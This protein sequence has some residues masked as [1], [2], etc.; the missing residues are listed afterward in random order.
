MPAG[1]VH[2]RAGDVERHHFLRAALHRVDQ[3]EAIDAVV[4][5]RLRL[6]VHFLEPRH[7]S[8]GCRLQH[9][10]VGWTILERA[11]EVLG[12][13]GVADAIAIGEDDAVGVVAGDGQ[14][15]R[16][17]VRRVGGKRD[18]LAAAE[19]HL[20]GR[21]RP[22]GEDLHPDA[23]AGRRVDVAAVGLGPRREPQAGRIGVVDV[24]PRHARRDRDRN[25][26]GRRGHGA[27]DDAILEGRA[28][29]W[30]GEAERT[31]GIAGHLA[32]APAIAVRDL[33]L[34]DDRRAVA[35]K[36]C[37]DRE[38]RAGLDPRV[39]RRHLEADAIGE[40]GQRRRVDRLT[41]GTARR[42]QDDREDHRGG[43]GAEPGPPQRFAR[44]N[45]LDIDRRRPARGVGDHHLGKR[46]RVGRLGH[47]DGGRQPIAERRRALLDV[48]RHLAV[49]RHASQ[50]QERP[51][52]RTRR[53]Q[54]G[55]G[56]ERHQPDRGAG[57]P[58][59]R[60]QRGA[61]DER[62]DQRAANERPHRDHRPPAGAD[63]IQHVADLGSGFRVHAVRAASTPSAA[64]SI[65]IA[66]SAYRQRCCSSS[67]WR[68]SPRVWTP[69][70]SFNRVT[71]D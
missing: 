3:L 31:G 69:P 52:Q 1:H 64:S 60:N 11:D 42:E 62:G 10:H 16:Q 61:D 37:L 50:R 26:V 39:A 8:I 55:R 20:A 51:S 40:Q 34:R 4:V 56:R 48:A 22:I 53:Q 21:R 43:G 65:A 27:G 17:L 58:P 19:R 13:A 36:A 66:E 59:R 7:G 70:A 57:R 29:R 12:V 71:A 15:R 33:H 35:D 24:D 68:P 2:A 63:A 32:H 6:D 14:R 46:R 49:G 9:A 38:R 18:R 5:F 54:R 30:H 25:L 45:G 47:V 67:C 28:N 41:R 44:H 23:G